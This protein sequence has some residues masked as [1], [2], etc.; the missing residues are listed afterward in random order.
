MEPDLSHGIAP[1]M[2]VLGLGAVAVD[3]I[4]Y[5]DHFP[6]ADSKMPVQR[7][8]RR[9]GGNAGTALVAARRM[10]RSC[11]Y[12]G[13]LDDRDELSRFIISAF[14]AE[15]VST[16]HL[17]RR[18][19]TRPVHSTILMDT[20]GKTRTILFDI[21]AAVGADPELPS[22]EVIRST[23]VL[24]VDHI[25]IAGMTRAARLARRAGIPVV[26]D[27]EREEDALFPEL[28]SLGDHLIL[29]YDFARGITGGK[30]PADILRALWRADRAAVVITRGAEGSWYLTAE[31]PGAVYCQPAFRV[32][33]VDTNG[34]GDIFHG[35]Y[36]AGLCE[37][38]GAAERIRFASA[39]SALKAMRPGGQ[40][41]IPLRAAAERFLRERSSEA[42]RA[43]V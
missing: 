42:P 33:A 7:G 5:L 3:D 31:E 32:A 9:A 18:P 4:L 21:R 34:C 41:A 13:S 28:L 19:G 8:E 35:V 36:A 29:P 25:G 27:L 30:S 10:G 17:V 2:D 39:V 26:A 37:G 16:R 15:G 14:E 40:A 20:L 24:L 22:E 11:D 43:A 12:A 38:L 1:G 6:E 23:R